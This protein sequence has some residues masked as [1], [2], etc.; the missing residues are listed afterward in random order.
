MKKILFLMIAFSLALFANSDSNVSEKGNSIT[1][2]SV[3]ASVIGG[4]DTSKEYAVVA[5]DKTKDF[6]AN[7][8]KKVIKTSVN[9]ETKTIYVKTEICV[10]KIINFM[11]KDNV[12]M[13][14]NDL[15]KF[16]LNSV[17]EVKNK[18]KMDGELKLT[19]E[20]GEET[21]RCLIKESSYNVIQ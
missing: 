4:Y 18:Y 15:D 17:K 3:K 14:R 9:T 5:Y 6:F 20:T 16:H 11:S 19:S 8:E 7:A 12:G 10:M 13:L 1:V 21:Y 2:E